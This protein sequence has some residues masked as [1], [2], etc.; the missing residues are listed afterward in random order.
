M[1]QDEQKIVKITAEW[2]NGKRY[3]IEE[4]EV[5]Q[6]LRAGENSAIQGYL[7]LAFAL[8]LASGFSW[9]EVR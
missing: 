6:L 7:L 3:T 2:G 4:P 1:K 8:N 9:R 5:T